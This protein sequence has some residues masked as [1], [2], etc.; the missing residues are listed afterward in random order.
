MKITG[1]K[2]LSSLIL[3][4]Y[5]DCLSIGTLALLLLL[6]FELF[7]DGVAIDDEEG[8]FAQ[9]DETMATC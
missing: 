5:H 1:A 8:L 6:P 3:G 2:S 9:F 7:V 4:N